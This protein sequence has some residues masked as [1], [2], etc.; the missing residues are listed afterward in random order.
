MTLP[1]LCS[2]SVK[3]LG[4]LAQRSGSLARQNIVPASLL[5]GRAYAAEPVPAEGAYS[6]AYCDKCQAN[7]VNGIFGC[8]CDLYTT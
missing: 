5:Q 1:R 4:R 2:E 3:A 7:H 6:Q 8:A